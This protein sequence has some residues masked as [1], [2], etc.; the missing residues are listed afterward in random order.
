MQTTL[1]TF[2]TAAVVT[3]AAA[4]ASHPA[5]AAGATVNVPF[6]FTASGKQ[7][8][9]GRYNIR[10]EKM[11]QVVRLTDARGQVNLVWLAG[12]GNPNPSDKRVVLRFDRAGSS[13]AL[14]SVQDGAT[15]TSRL[16]KQAPSEQLTEI[17]GQ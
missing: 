9:A 16:D 11:N 8:P 13:Y 14:R 4:L 12:P 5:M 7:C 15:I 2:L 3:A 17:L 1:R 10:L 6:S